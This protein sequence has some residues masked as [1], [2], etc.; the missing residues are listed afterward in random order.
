MKRTSHAGQQR[1]DKVVAALRLS[2]IPQE[3]NETSMPD[4]L[5]ALIQE[6]DALCGRVSELPNMTLELGDELVMLDTIV[7]RFRLLDQ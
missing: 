4:N 3:P 6:L 2:A 7:Q 1:V 5:G